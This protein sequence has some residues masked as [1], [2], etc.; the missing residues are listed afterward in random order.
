MSDIS[1]RLDGLL[2]GMAIL[3]GLGLFALIA[4]VSALRALLATPADRR[5]WRVTIRSLWLVLAHAVALALVIAY[6][7]RSAFHTGPDWID[8]LAIPWAVFILAALIL[9]FRRARSRGT[10]P[11]G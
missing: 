1:I 10:A 2:L 5:S 8:W 7:D 6:A 4:F 3:A 11:D 9:L